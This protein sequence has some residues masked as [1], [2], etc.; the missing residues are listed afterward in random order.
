VR[1]DEPAPALWA[2]LDPAG[3]EAVLPAG[4]VLADRAVA[5]R[6]CYR[7]LEGTAAAHA[8]GGAQAE[9]TVGS[10]IGSADH[11]GLPA[12]PAGLTVRL[13]T[14]ARIIVFDPARLTSLI[15]ADQD[16]AAS[17]HALRHLG[18]IGER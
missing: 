2:R 16:A 8:E 17:W 15:E 13:L 5:S 11:R 12:A 3:D 18:L 7:I 4:T 10:F 1:T 14:P 6:Q 9:L